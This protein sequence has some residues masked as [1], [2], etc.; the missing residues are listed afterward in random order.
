MDESRPTK[1]NETEDTVKS[2]KKNP[3]APDSLSDKSTKIEKPKDI[4]IR[5]ENSSISGIYG[6]V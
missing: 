4:D 2:V 1:I 3:I 5:N 6:H